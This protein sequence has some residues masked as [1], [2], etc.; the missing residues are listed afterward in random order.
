VVSCSRQFRAAQDFLVSRTM[1]VVL[2][3]LYDASLMHRVLLYLET[4]LKR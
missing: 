3:D 2:L 1:H 4:N